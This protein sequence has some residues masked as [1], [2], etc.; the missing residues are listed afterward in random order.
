MKK[1][2]DPNDLEALLKASIAEAKLRK[3]QGVSPQAPR[4]LDFTNPA[5]WRATG[6]VQLVHRE[7]E[8]NIET[9]VGLFEEFIH[10]RVPS[11]RRLVAAVEP[12]TG[13]RP[14]IEYV[15]GDHWI[16]RELAQQKRL[17]TEE[18]ISITEDLVLSCGVACPGVR[19]SC[20]LAAGGL[21]RVILE[22]DTVFEGKTPRIFLEVHRGVD[23]LDALSEDTKISIWRQ[24]KHA[25]DEA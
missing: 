12:A 18:T 22:A 19:V 4:G 24:V 9:L 13:V 16:G 14:R 5:S 23:T 17:R 3:A 21:S 7:P 20:V 2:T 1:G 8:G 10:T 11:T 15:T 6:Q 25:Q